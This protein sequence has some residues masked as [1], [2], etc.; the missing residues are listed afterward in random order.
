MTIDLMARQPRRPARV[1]AH[2]RAAARTLVT[3]YVAERASTCLQQGFREAVGMDVRHPVDEVEAGA[4]GALVALSVETQDDRDHRWTRCRASSPDLAE[5]GSD[6]G[7]RVCTGRGG[8][9]GCA[10]AS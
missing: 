8:V 4:A 6:Q 7:D 2:S 9:C 5:I 3:R 1:N 10:R